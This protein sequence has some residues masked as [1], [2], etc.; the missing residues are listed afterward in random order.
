MAGM[1][2]ARAATL[3]AELAE[4][5]TSEYGRALALAVTA[6]TPK[7]RTAKPKMNRHVAAFLKM[8]FPSGTTTVP[9]AEMAALRAADAKLSPEAAAQFAYGRRDR[10][11]PDAAVL[12]AASTAAE[13]AAAG[14]ELA[15][16]A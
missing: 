14:Y 15:L 8:R 1:T 13:K 16:A 7:P 5:D 4:G 9:Y 11:A 10:R 2:K 12:Y 3:L 6:L